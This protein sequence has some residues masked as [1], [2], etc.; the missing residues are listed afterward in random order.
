MKYRLL[1]I[2]LLPFFLLYN[3]LQGG[4]FKEPLGVNN[5]KLRQQNVN[6]KLL[7]AAYINSK[8][9]VQEALSEGAIVDY[10]SPLDSSVRYIT[11]IDYAVSQPYGSLDI[12]RSLLKK[13]ANVN[14]RF[15]PLSLAV[16]HKKKALVF[17]L[18]QAGASLKTLDREG[19]NIVYY[20]VR[21]NS[22]IIVEWL[23]R[24]GANVNHINHKG[25]TPLDYAFK[26]YKNKVL[27][28][29]FNYAAISLSPETHLEAY[30]LATR[31][32]H[33]KSPCSAVNPCF[34]SLMLLA[35]K[36]MLENICLC[37]CR[38]NRYAELDTIVRSICESASIKLY[39]LVLLQY[40]MALELIDYITLED[41][42]DD[43]HVP[44]NVSQEGQKFD[45]SLGWI[46]ALKKTESELKHIIT[47][48]ENIDMYT[49]PDSFYNTGR[50]IFSE[51][52][53]KGNQLL[54][55]K[56]YLDQLDIFLGNIGMVAV[57]NEEELYKYIGDIIIKNFKILYEH[58]SG[59]KYRK[60]ICN[61]QNCTSA[62]CTE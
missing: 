38:D 19:N 5:P 17:V 61:K 62:C 53:E 58:G 9:K 33:Q 31:I 28:T 44:I 35:E 34:S 37:C 11:A 16:E 8:A 59:L 48:E 14:T 47:T 57:S 18:L 52:T 21:S 26:N 43:C 50:C 20:G 2:A 40:K 51:P 6:E 24:G 55:I 39:K 13:K 29:L 27:I 23:L 32:L 22:P 3:F 49:M 4:N 12:V 7:W 60:H 25:E 46:T 56:G 1:F 30:S 10:T 36:E 42:K 54:I 41:M 45:D 15:W